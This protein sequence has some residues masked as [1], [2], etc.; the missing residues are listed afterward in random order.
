MT[1]V[2]LVDDSL[3]IRTVIKNMLIQEHCE[4]IGEAGT[5]RDAIAKFCSLLPDVI[6][7]DYNMP[8][9]NGID[10][11]RHILAQ[12]ADAKIIMITSIGTD[13]QIE[14]ARQVGIK[15]Y[16]TKPFKRENI[17]AKLSEVL[18]AAKK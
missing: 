11:A 8:D 17:A 6:L 7:M 12:N 13:E 18:G 14:R 1:R 15:G 10:V 16:L 3:L 4:V 9:M 5:G 2:L